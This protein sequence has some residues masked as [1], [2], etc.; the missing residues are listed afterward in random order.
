MAAVVRSSVQLFGTFWRR[1]SPRK[2]STFA[3]TL[4][5]HEEHAVK[6]TKMWKYMSLF[7]AIPGVIAVAV[8]AYKTEQEHIAHIEEHGRPE[9]I[10]YTHLRIRAKPFPWGDGNHS[11][12][13]NPHVNALPEG[14][15]DH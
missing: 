1:Q 7:V 3:E 6:T 10:P 2:L 5:A 4:Q 8:K 14:Y 12:I 11:L 13:H 9:F 15:E